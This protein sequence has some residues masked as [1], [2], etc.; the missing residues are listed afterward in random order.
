MTLDE[1]VVLAEDRVDMLVA[2]D[3][4]LTRL[5]VLDERLGRVVECRS[6][7]GLSDEE[8]AAALQVRSRTV[9]RDWAKVKGWLYQELREGGEV[10]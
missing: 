9:R 4:A 1:A 7:G 10:G 3:E 6:F 2:L 8:T 5:L